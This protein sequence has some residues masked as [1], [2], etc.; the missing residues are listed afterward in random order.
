MGREL[1]K[2]LASLRHHSHYGITPSNVNIEIDPNQYDESIYPKLN[3]SSM[4]GTMM[5][6]LKDDISEEG[7]S[8][9]QA[10]RRF[11]EE[12]ADKRK[13]MILEKMRKGDKND[14]GT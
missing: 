8:Y 14:Q 2:T 13:K 10:A 4:Y 5:N 11:Y 9:Q 12:T 6:V 3:L 1:R 7:L